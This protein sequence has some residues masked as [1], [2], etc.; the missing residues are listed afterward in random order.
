M[1]GEGAAEG[2]C[3]GWGGRGLG[4]PSCPSIPL[5]GKLR[6][7]LLGHWGAGEGLAH[8]CFSGPGLRERPRW[9]RD[10]APPS[11]TPGLEFGAG[12]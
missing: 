10:R 6:A 4:E 3:P 2:V 1:T 11:A 7:W 8:P 9:L 12:S 5:D